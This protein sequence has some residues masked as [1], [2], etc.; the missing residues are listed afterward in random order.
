MALRDKKINLNCDIKKTHSK[1]KLVLSMTPKSSAEVRYGSGRNVEDSLHHMNHLS[2]CFEA[3]I[4]RLQ[5][6]GR[7]IKAI[8]IIQ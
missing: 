7:L 2:V 3:L 5:Y 6:K 8:A 4:G 1:K